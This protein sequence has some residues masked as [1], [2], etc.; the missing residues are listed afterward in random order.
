MRAEA[1]RKVSNDF[2]QNALWQQPDGNLCVMRCCVG[3]P[4][5]ARVSEI[6]ESEILE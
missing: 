5:D 4:A 6:P 3:A 1:G 2:T